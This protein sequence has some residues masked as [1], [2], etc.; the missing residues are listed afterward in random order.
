MSQLPSSIDSD[1]F[2]AHPRTVWGLFVA[3]LAGLVLLLVALEELGVPQPLVGLAILATTLAAYAGIGLVAGSTQSVR[4]LLAGLAVPAGYNGMAAAA[5][6]L[7]AAWFLLYAGLFAEWGRG[8][9]ALGLGAGIGLGAGAL[10]L[11]APLRRAE[12]VTT[13]DFLARRTGSPSVRLAASLLVIAASFMLFAVVLTGIAEITAAVLAVPRAWSVTAGALLLGLMLLPGGMR[14]ATW[15]QVAQ[16][17]V[18]AAAFLVPAIMVAI[19]RFGWPLPQLAMA[20]AQSRLESLAAADADLAGLVEGQAIFGRFA[21]SE[22]AAMALLAAL[23][24]LALPHVLERYLTAPSV[25]SARRTGRW[26]L[27][28][29]GLLIITAPAYAALTFL[30]QVEGLVGVPL[31]ELPDWAFLHGEAGYLVIC[32][33]PAVSP[34]AILAAC[35]GRADITGVSLADIDLAGEATVIRFAE[36][37]G[38]SFVLSALVFVGALSAALSTASGLLTSLTSTASHDLQHSLIAP[39][40]PMGKRLLAARLTMLV[41]ITLAAMW[42]NQPG[43]DLF[44]IAFLA[45]GL[46]AAGIGPALLAGALRPSLKALPVLASM[47]AGSATMLTLFVAEHYGADLL[48]ASGDEWQ[49]F[50]L[51]G[52]AEAG[53]PSGAGVFV[54]LAASLAVLVVAQMLP[55]RAL[56]WTRRRRKKLKISSLEETS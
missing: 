4:F 21:P 28:F 1:V 18:M 29:A 20:E 9:F 3:L 25:A 19:E 56:S 6:F 5:A 43:H 35:G 38:L 15:T 53:I 10:L 22:L 45:L 7:S 26:M 49:P 13:A 39:R 27:L 50:A 17:L 41:A 42:A 37:A 51:Q 31:A 11:A 36:R 55:Q 30:T 32:G 48:P 46:L 54:A 16:Y 47:L 52:L 14:G 12:A 2:A 24:S 8:A 33:T 44:G 23:L 40:A 34:D